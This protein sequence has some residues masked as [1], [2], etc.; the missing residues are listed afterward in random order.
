MSAAATVP[1]WISAISTAVIA[2]GVVAAALSW[3][4]RQGR[5]LRDPGEAPGGSEGEQVE[6]IQDLLWDEAGSRN[7]RRRFRKR[8]R[9]KQ[10]DLP[11]RERWQR[12]LRR[13]NRRRR[14]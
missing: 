9:E 13:R 1:D 6:A 4:R 7:D 14:T 8:M 12:F 3:M 2:L 10:R 11:R 5:E